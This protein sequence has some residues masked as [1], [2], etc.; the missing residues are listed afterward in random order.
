MAGGVQ[1][2]LRLPPAIRQ[3]VLSSG[4]LWSSS[5][6]IC[7]TGQHFNF[8]PMHLHQSRSFTLS[9]SLAKNKQ[10]V[11][12]NAQPQK[13]TPQAHNL[14]KRTTPAAKF[15]PGSAPPIPNA[16]APKP[17]ST[18]AP[19]LNYQDWISSRFPNTEQ[20]LLYVSPNHGGFFAL[21]FFCGFM[22]L[23][24][25]YTQSQLFLKDEEGKPARPWYIK[26][27]GAVPILGFT[28]LGTTFVLAPLKVIKSVTLIKAA[29]ARTVT[30]GSKLRMEIKRLLPF[31][32]PDIL[33]VEPS[34]FVLDRSIPSSVHDLRFTNYHIKDTKG[35]NEYYFSG[36]LNK[37]EG[38]A[39]KRFNTGLLNSWPGLVKNTKR[40]FMRYQMAYV[41]IPGNG[42][43]KLD[44]QGC[45]LLDQGNVLAKI[46]TEDVNIDRGVRAFIK[47]LTGAARDA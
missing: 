1:L 4:T 41:R 47:N 23:L 31:S 28:A 15:S 45:H 32:K 43:F 7:R 37:K 5:S 24:A 13:P 29:D 9:S 18:P 26:A 22:F 2:L 38:S 10:N 17:S 14:P 3:Q 8:G 36:E 34:N 20:V 46:A 44:L 42:N 33:E 40:M 39:F 6:S 11:F 21:S 16:L 19:R 27:I 30:Q 25:A 12:K 35:F